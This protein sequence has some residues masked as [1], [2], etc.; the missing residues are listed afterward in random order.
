M[1]NLNFDL[2]CKSMTNNEISLIVAYA[3]NKV[4][5]NNHT[6]P[7]SIPGE[8]KR[9]KELTT[10]NVVI[11]GRH[12]FE[13]IY[14]K[15]GHTLSNRTTIVVSKSQ[16]FEA[17]GCITASSFG[18]AFKIARKN[19]WDKNVYVCG[20]ASIY[21]EALPLVEK[22]YIT[23]IDLEVEGDAFFP[24]FIADDF[25]VQEDAHFEGEI[26]YTYYTYTRK[27]RSDYN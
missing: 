11:M 25:L 24:E 26:P 6:I 4:I 21:R 7:W 22:M 1:R 27:S 12:T 13:E 23:E 20:G 9:F 18:E 10:G 17:M 8:Q 16:T 19:Y 15:L 2:Y 3:K 14:R 5:G